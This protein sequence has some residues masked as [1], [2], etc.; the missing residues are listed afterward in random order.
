MLNDSTA[1]RTVTA[2]QT[3]AFAGFNRPRSHAVSTVAAVRQSDGQDVKGS[4]DVPVVRH[5]TRRASPLSNI[6][7]HSIV[8][9]SADRT[10]FAR[11][12]PAVNADKRPPMPRTL[13]LQH[14]DQFAPAG[15]ANCSGKTVVRHHAAHVQV[16]DRDHLVFANQAGRKLLQIVAANIRNL[17]VDLGHPELCLAPILR[18]FLFSGESL[19]RA[20]QLRHLAAQWTRRIM[21]AA[22]GEG[23]EGG[24]PEVDTNLARGLRKNG[25]RFVHAEGNVVKTSGRSAHMNRGGLTGEVS[26]PSDIDFADF[27]ERQYLSVPAE[28]RARELCRLTTIALLKVRIVRTV[29]PKVDERGL[30]V[31]QRLLDRDTTHFVEPRY[32]RLPLQLRQR[33]RRSAVVDS[34]LPFTPRCAAQIQRPIEYVAGTAK[35]LRE[36]RRLLWSGI[37]TVV[38][39]TNHQAQVWAETTM[40][41]SKRKLKLMALAHERRSV[42]R[43]DSPFLSLAEA[44]G[45]SEK[46]G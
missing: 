4:I 23:R 36:R 20:V 5:A 8:F 13:V 17:L 31:A 1:R 35:R 46:T 27:G 18:A 43:T 28:S 9:E 37:E 11:W 22:V 12:K 3:A 2:S 19:L 38:E 14:A 29:P 25:Q 24:Q 7:R 21:F 16:F 15:I 44:R 32:I 42:R 30:Q 34:L 45:L 39:A 10:Q 6:E 33:C 41:K 40:F 26:G